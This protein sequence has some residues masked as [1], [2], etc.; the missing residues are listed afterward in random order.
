MGCV[1]SPQ[2]RNSIVHDSEVIQPGARFAFSLQV[3]PLHFTNKD[4]QLLFSVI[5]Q[6][7][8]GSVKALERGKFKVLNVEIYRPVIEK[9]EK[10]GAKS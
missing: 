5:G 7:G 6:I 2:G 1:S 8:L 3:P 9:K 10:R 4:I